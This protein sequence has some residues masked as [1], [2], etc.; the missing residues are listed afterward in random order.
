MVSRPRDAGLSRVRSIRPKVPQ[1][2]RLAAAA[3]LLGVSVTRLASAEPAPSPGEI[4][5]LDLSG[6]FRT[7]SAWQVT[8][9]Q[10]APIPDPFGPADGTVPGAVTVCLHKTNGPCDTQL[11]SK[12]FDTSDVAAF[13]E[14]HY[15]H[16]L[17]VGR[18][19][20]AFGQPLLLLVTASLHSGDG[21]Q[22]V[23]TQVMAYR[24][25]PDRLVKAYEHWTGTNN[26]QEVRL[27]PAGPLAG[28]II[29]VEPTDTA[30]FGY[31]V[32]VNVFTPAQGYRPVLRFRSATTYADGNA[33]PVIDSEMANILR[34]RGL[35]R[36]GSPLPLPATPCAKPHLR[37]MELWCD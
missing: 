20:G 4:A 10:A 28:D 30:P 1:A 23:L 34:R 11:Q 24:G 27:M 2:R 22:L 9:M 15:L 19:Q 8:A 6:P 16:K 21:D 25:S 35:W 14:R 5:A 33:L 26:N 3:L 13:S 29:A 12:L 7:R 36:P 32:T 37:R 31:W 18:S 17:A